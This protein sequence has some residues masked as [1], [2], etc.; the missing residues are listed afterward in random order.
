MNSQLVLRKFNHSDI[1]PL[2]FLSSLITRYL[3]ILFENDTVNIPYLFIKLL[4]GAKDVVTVLV[5]VVSASV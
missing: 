3:A 4:K 1:C 2:N 5:V